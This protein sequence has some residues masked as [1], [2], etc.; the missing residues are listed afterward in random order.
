[1]LSPDEA[2]AM[3][4][5]QPKNA[6]VIFPYLI[7]EDL[8]NEPGGRPTRWVIDFGA[9]DQLEARRFSR[10]FKRVEEL[11][12]PDRERAAAEE[13]TRNATLGKA[14]NRHHENFLRH[15]WQLSYARGA[16]LER[17]GTLSR[18]IVCSRVTKR[19]IF[20]FVSTAIHP[21]DALAVFPL[22][23]DYSFGILQSGLHWGWF[24][25]RCSTL[26]GDWRYTSNTVFDS[27][28]WP[29]TAT[30]AQVAAVARAAVALRAL[31][32]DLCARHALSLRALYVF[33]ENPGAH[34]LKDAHAA[35]DAAVRAAYGMGARQDPLAFLL[36][37]NLACAK[38]EAEDTS[39][40]GPGVP[41]GVSAKGLV[42]GDAVQPPKL[43]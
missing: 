41:P 31:R 3:C 23:D 13:R 18:Y 25:A 26:K 29:Q 34:P 36:D 38:R 15:W 6:E 22:A 42:T 14:G 4:V 28:P 35:L 33:A 20:A 37:L 40:V 39:I 24:K 16:L 12:L 21:S 32:R 5:A 8:V 2:R 11:V 1:L 7:G 17:L 10:P 19:P 30:P 43:A 9:L 27:F